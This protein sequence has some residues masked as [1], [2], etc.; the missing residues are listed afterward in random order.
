MVIAEKER[1]GNDEK[2]VILEVMG[3]V[4]GKTAVVVDDFTIS[5]GTLVDVSV[6]LMEQGAKPVY[7]AVTHGVLP[8]GSVE[9]ID[10]SP[11]KQLIISDTPENQPVQFSEKIEWGY[12]SPNFEK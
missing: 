11:I 2:G 1:H 8:R 12:V 9:R 10:K 4:K 7:A 6:K 3:K 5:G